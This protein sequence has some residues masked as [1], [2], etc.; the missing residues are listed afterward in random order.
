MNSLK[1]CTVLLFCLMCG[2]HQVEAQQYIGGVIYEDLTLTE[3]ES[4]YIIT[5]KLIIEDSVVLTINPGVEVL[6]VDSTGIRVEGTVFAKGSENNPIIFEPLN[7]DAV[8]EGISFLE[9]AEYND[10]IDEVEYCIFRRSY[11]SVISTISRDEMVVRNCVFEDHEGYALKIRN[12]NETIIKDNE[13]RNCGYGLF[14]SV[15][16]S[17]KDNVVED[18]LFEDIEGAGIMVFGQSGVTRDNVFQRNIIRNCLY[19]VYVIGGAKTSYNYFL[20]NKVVGNG[21]GFKI[22]N[23]YNYIQ[24]NEIYGNATGISIEGEQDLGGANNQVSENIIYDNEIGISCIRYANQNTLNEN[25]IYNN[26]IGIYLDWWSDHNRGNTITYNYFSDNDSV[27]LLLA[28]APQEQINNNDFVN[29]RKQS[30]ILL[31]DDDQEAYNNY[32]GYETQEEIESVIFHHP[33]DETSGYVLYDPFINSGNTDRVKAPLFGGKKLVGDTVVLTWDASPTSEVIG[34]RIYSKA[35]TEYDYALIQD[36]SNVLEHETVDLDI[37]NDIVVTAYLEGADGIDD[38]LEGLESGYKELDFLPYAGTDKLACQGGTVL[39]E[40][41]TAFH[42]DSVQWSTN[43][44]GVLVDEE[45]VLAT[46]ISDDEDVGKDIRFWLSQYTDDILYQDSVGVRILSSAEVFAGNDTLIVED[47][48]LK[49]KYATEISCDSVAWFT[50]GDGSF[51]DED[52]LATIYLPG[53]NDILNGEVALL[54]KG[55]G[56]CGDVSDTMKVRFYEGFVISGSAD[57]DGFA[58]GEVEAFYDFDADYKKS[59][60]L[61][62]DENKDFTLSAIPKAFTY[63]RYLP[64]NQTDYLPTYYVNEIHWEDAYAL[65]VSGDVYDVDIHVQKPKYQLPV[66]VGEIV[67]TISRSGDSFY[68]ETP[69]VFLCDESE[70]VLKWILPNEE[71]V[72]SFSD[73]PF[74]NYR[75]GIEKVGVPYYISDILAV[76]PENPSVEDLSILIEGKQVELQVQNAE[77]QIS[78]YPTLFRESISI[79]GLKNEVSYST[80]IYSVGGTLVHNQMI[81]RGFSSQA[82]TLSLSGLDE[83]MYFISIKSDTEQVVKRLIKF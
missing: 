46:Y 72:F 18:N 44:L 37:F 49:I 29:P 19:G 51:S 17:C 74:G 21:S 22:Q 67:G 54:L 2:V 78:V 52:N 31:A 80:Q 6:F 33:D 14:F 61:V 45:L 26:N 1:Y 8:W 23:E 40:E 66:G 4:P 42:F 75:I 13:I 77:E 27:S 48:S 39:F 65:F 58:E 10:Y 15:D 82:F 64:Q 12:C 36:V 43:G 68:D 28:G 62:M 79:L 25:Q 32:W 83:G 35:D 47:S 55:Y 57:Y 16:I 71:G 81:N 9:P 20:T 50:L 11:Y 59:S 38:Q 3:E 30:V 5:E 53:E 60:A 76:S 24:M 63:V 41:A 69:I 73:L 7:D 56:I 70:Y 34:Y